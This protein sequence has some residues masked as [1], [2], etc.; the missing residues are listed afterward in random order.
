MTFLT[1]NL[2]GALLSL[3]IGALLYFAGGAYGLYSLALM[4]AFL[5]LSAIVTSIGADFKKKIG[6]FQAAR[7]VKNVLANGLP[8]S[9]ILIVGYLAAISNHPEITALSIIGFVGAVA[10]ITADKFSSELGVFGGIPRMILG[11]KRVKRGTSGGITTLGLFASLAAS[12]IIAATFSIYESS[13][14]LIVILTFS[15]LFG[16]IVDSILGCFEE[17]GIG[18]KYTSNFLCGL[19]GAVAAVLLYLLISSL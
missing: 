3:V 8:P 12:F 16:S 1:L 2:Q 18:N 9:L 17:R 4:L 14:L 10:A 13:I 11:F 6:T 7:G 5:A 15:G 19:S